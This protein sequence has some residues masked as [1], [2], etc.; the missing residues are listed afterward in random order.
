MNERICSMDV[1]LLL[2]LLLLYRFYVALAGNA[3]R[4]L[5]WLRRARQVTE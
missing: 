1:F 5:L 4:N 3:T 2:L